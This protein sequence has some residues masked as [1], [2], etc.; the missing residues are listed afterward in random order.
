MKMLVKFLMSSLYLYATAIFLFVLM[1]VV[2][3][4]DWLS[5]IH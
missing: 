4:D 5:A 3:I 2:A 1:R